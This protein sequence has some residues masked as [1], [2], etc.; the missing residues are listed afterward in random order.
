[1]QQ[2][3]RERP[4]VGNKPR[5]RPDAGI[6][7]QVA[8]AKRG[9]R[10]A[11]AQLYRGHVARVYDY[12]ARRLPDAHAA[13]EATQEVFYRAFRGLE[14]CRTET[15]FAGWLF[16]IA[17]NVI[18]DVYRARRLRTEALDF[19]GDPE[20]PALPPMEQV[21]RSERRDE[22][23]AM[24]EHC[25]SASERDLFDLLLSDLTDQEIATAL[26]R[27]YG[28]IRTAH[29]RLL[30]KLKNCFESMSTER[31]ADHVAV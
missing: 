3:L 30:G 31:G 28:A 21:L 24:R 16:G 7:E 1:M 23:L 27:R 6:A 15:L 9:D 14:H 29:W 5:T 18:A 10:E 13:E 26:G 20:D 4:A 17:R 22:L 8:A 11:F 2:P 19:A 25:L 12:A